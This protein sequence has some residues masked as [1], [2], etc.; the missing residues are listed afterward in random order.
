MKLKKCL[1]LIL[2]AS[3]ALSGMVLPSVASAEG[4]YGTVT[5]NSDGSKTLT[6]GVDS[7]TQSGGGS[8][9]EDADNAGYSRPDNLKTDSTGAAVL[10]LPEIDL[11]G[12]GYDKI[13]L[14]AACQ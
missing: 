1:A 2:S 14:Y 13:D 3:M 8:F 6:F 4:D 7:I 9:G 10:T 12:S 11:N 5:T